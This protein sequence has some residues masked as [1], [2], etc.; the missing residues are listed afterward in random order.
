MHG[1]PSNAMLLEHVNL[2]LG[3]GRAAFDLARQFLIDGLGLHHDPRPAAR[4]RGESLLWA[5]AGLQQLHLPVDDT[6]AAGR[7]LVEPKLCQQLD[8]E[9]VLEVPA[10]TVGQFRGRLQSL[11]H[12]CAEAADEGRPALRTSALG[13]TFVL[14]EAAAADDERPLDPRR[15]FIGGPADGCRGQPG[16]TAAECA[17]AAAAAAPCPTGLASVRI[18]APQQQ[19]ASLAAFWESVLGARVVRGAGVRDSGGGNRG[20]ATSGSDAADGQEGDTTPA[21][22]ARRRLL[23]R[24][25]AAIDDG[26]EEGQQQQQQRQRQRQRLLERVTV[27][28]DGARR[29][30]ADV[31]GLAAPA[32]AA[33]CTQTIEF[34]APHLLPPPP[35]PP[36]LA[37]SPAPLAPSAAALLPYDGHHLAVYLRDWEGAY[38][39]AAAGGLLFNNLRF[40]DRCGTWEEA[41]A[42]QQFRTL[43]MAAETGEGGPEGPPF[44]LELEVRSLQHPACPY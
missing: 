2:N 18:R 28:F 7:P 15:V 36:P 23:E 4:G 19:L 27:A 41:A 3:L 17:A 34:V 24:G 16:F 32:N 33:R 6:D 9:L 37:S 20:E 35:P 10:G 14:R 42:C 29:P 1:E 21:A 12:A 25:A 38:R 43:V 30:A 11:G 26:D 22:A 44:L 31:A 39:R 8:G 13:N 5:N 40:S